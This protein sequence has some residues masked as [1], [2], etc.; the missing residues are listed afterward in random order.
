M[1]HEPVG[2]DRDHGISHGLD[3]QVEPLELSGRYNEVTRHYIRCNRD[4]V[5]P[6]DFQRILSRDWPED[7]IHELNCGHSPFFSNP[8]ELADILLRIA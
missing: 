8:D 2:S 7:R 4:R 1:H 3:Q 6:P 5:I